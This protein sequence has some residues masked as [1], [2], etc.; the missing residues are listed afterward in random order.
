[1]RDSIFATNGVGSVVIMTATGH[2][3]QYKNM[4]DTREGRLPLLPTLKITRHK[5]EKS[6]YLVAKVVDAIKKLVKNDSQND[7]CKSSF[8]ECEVCK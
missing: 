2:Y 1:M 8:V 7:N 6:R 3:L 4:L 5:K